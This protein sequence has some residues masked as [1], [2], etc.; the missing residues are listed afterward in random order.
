MERAAGPG[1]GPVRGSRGRGRRSPAEEG[2]GDGRPDSRG[3]G[4]RP[5]PPPRGQPPS[6][7][8]TPRALGRW[9][10]R[11]P[12][13]RAAGGGGALGRRLGRRGGRRLSRRRPARARLPRPHRSPRAC[14]ARGPQ[15]HPP[16]PC[17][18]S[19]LRGRC[20]PIAQRGRTH[21]GSACPR[22]SAAGLRSAFP[23]PPPSFLS[24][25]FC[26]LQ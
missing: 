13:R 7:P 11:G 17:E 5:P 14:G 21:R 4:R 1:L 9:L 18:P 26:V 19:R 15:G 10:G 8:P 20:S 2:G 22:R 23:A 3:L 25:C 16:G 12:G 6:R 24:V